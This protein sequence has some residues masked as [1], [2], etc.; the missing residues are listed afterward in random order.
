MSSSSNGRVWALVRMRTAISL[1]GALPASGLNVVGHPAR[2]SAFV[3]GDV[4]L[5]RLT[6]LAVGEQV[7]FR[8]VRDW[9]Q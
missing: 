5:Y 1:S 6:T 8:D 7:L 4:E 3:C 9:W 2:F